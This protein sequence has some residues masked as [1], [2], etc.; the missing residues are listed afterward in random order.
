MRVILRWVLLPLALATAALVGAIVL[1]SQGVTGER[2]LRGSIQPTPIPPEIIAS[3]ETR[4]TQILFGDLHVHT[5]YSGDAFVF[6]LPLMQGE[7]VH[8]PADA[9]DFAR[10]CAELDFWSINDHAEGLTPWQWNETKQAIRECNAVAGDP[11]NPDLVSFLGWEWTQSA[12]VGR[13]SQRPHFGHKNVVLLDTEE[14]AVPTRP[15]GA[16]EGGLFDAPIPGSVWAL[17]RAGI[18]L[19]DLGNLRPYLDFNR[20]TRDVRNTDACPDDV[21]VRE[22]PSNCIEGASTPEKLFAKLDDWGFRSLVIPHG[23]SWG[24]H[25]PPTAEL[26]VQLEA[27]RND[28]ARQRLF[29]VY[30]GHGASEVHRELVDFELDE[31]GNRQCAPPRDGYLPCC[32]QAGEIIRGRCGDTEPE[33]CDARVA[34]TRALALERSAYSVVSGTRPGDWLECGQLPGGSLAAFEYRPNMSAQYGLAVREPAQGE[35]GAFRFG[36]IGSSDN[37]KARP[38]P[39]YKETQR[40]AFGD[41]YG[42]RRDWYDRISAP[43][44]PAPE[45]VEEPGLA[46]LLGVGFERGASFYYTAGLV[47]VHA[48]GRDRHSIFDALE[49][50]HAYG[51][52]GPRIQLWFNLENAP[53]GPALMGSEVGMDE[54]PR[55]V[56]RA[57]GAF[58]Q[59]PGCPAHTTERLSAERLER[60]CLNECHHPSDVRIPIDRIEVVRI[61]PQVTGDEPIGD[62]IDDPWRVFPCAADGS[63]C[64]V[65]FEDTAY[66][67]SEEI[68]Y[69]VRALQTATPAVNGSPMRCERDAQGRCLRARACPAAGPDFD[70]DDDCLSPVNERAWSSPI[71]VRPPG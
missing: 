43:G 7:G 1:L 52:S 12:P 46:G 11:A 65:H 40:K 3:R 60:L 55:F 47:A 36:L 37:H 22:L 17:L 25:A 2:H 4:Q 58:E 63:G 45:P 64:E 38:G 41:A 20:F 13:G 28:P 10:F 27:G 35:A 66:D 61:R 56:V 51:T 54:P 8:P 49:E 5:T 44:P 26:G 31:A 24:I 16:G 21:P 50:R 39:G 14:D 53:G 30:S 69:Y 48:P 67:G 29:E 23:T 71:W 32:W 57:S 42:L 34:R 18:T 19:G 62:R 68:L 9:C 15:I 33:V 70:P 6:S 59:L